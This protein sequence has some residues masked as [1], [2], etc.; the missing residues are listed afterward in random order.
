MFLLQTDHH[1]AEVL[2]H[3]VFEE[4]VNGIALLDAMFLEE[5]VG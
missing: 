2:A 5:L 4:V 1:A 3:E